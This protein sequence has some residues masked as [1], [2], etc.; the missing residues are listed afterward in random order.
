M[1]KTLLNSSFLNFARL[2]PAPSPIPDGEGGTGGP[3]SAAASV[4]GAEGV[5]EATPIGADAPWAGDDTW[6]IGEGEEAKDWYDLIPEEKVRESMRSKG[7]KNPA[8]VAMAYH[9][10]MGKQRNP[11]GTVQIPGEDA[12]DEERTAFNTAFGVPKAPEDYTI[13]AGEGVEHDPNMVSFLRN[14]AHKLG[15]NQTQTAGLSKEWDGFMAEMQKEQK[16]AQDAA[17]A[18]VKEKYGESLPKIQAEGQRAVKALGLTDSV[19][20]D[21]D[22]NLGTAGVVELLAAIGAKGGE[23]TFKGNGA[24]GDSAAESN[25]SK[26]EAQ[27]RINELMEDDK[28]QAAYQNSDHA[29]HKEA[30]KRME[31]LFALT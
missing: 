11:E 22:K 26:S 17:V 29:G 15:M 27:A 14:T 28:F 7:Y 5:A 10:L 19:I 31:R 30:L 21:L 3:S 16:V 4:I 18:T 23:A 6:K 24:G 25:L 20:A 1:H 13:E 9:S 2:M 8:E 12:T